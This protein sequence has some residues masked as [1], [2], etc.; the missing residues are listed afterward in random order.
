MSHPTGPDTGS[1]PGGPTSP[2]NPK[3]TDP[4]NPGMPTPPGQPGPGPK[5]AMSHADW[6]ALAQLVTSVRRGLAEVAS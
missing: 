2:G 5:K 6:L 1:P 3:L 4:T